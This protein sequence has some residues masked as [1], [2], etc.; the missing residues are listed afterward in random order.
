MAFA[1]S[2]TATRPEEPW[3]DLVN[4]RLEL[5]YTEAACERRGDVVEIFMAR[6]RGHG[7]DDMGDVLQDLAIKGQ[8]LQT[9]YSNLCSLMRLVQKID[10]WSTGFLKRKHEPVEMLR[11]KLPAAEPFLRLWKDGSHR[12]ASL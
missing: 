11:P 7:E 10:S 8:Q 2:T 5:P 4:D 9:L 3:E 1:S 12:W 6:L